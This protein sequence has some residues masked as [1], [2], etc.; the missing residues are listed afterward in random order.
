MTNNTG[1]LDNQ[2]PFLPS[3]DWEL[4]TAILEPENETYPW[5]LASD[6]VDAYFQKLAAPLY[7]D[8]L[9]MESLEQQ[10]ENFYNSLDQIWSQ[11]YNSKADR[12]ERPRTT[13]SDIFG[14]FVPSHYLDQIM[15]A[16]KK[17]F[18]NM[19]HSTIEK[20]VDCV[21]SLL[22]NWDMEDLL[23]LARP[24]AYSMRSGQS[25]YN[26]PNRNW[27][28]LSEVERAKICLVVADYALKAVST[29]AAENGVTR[30]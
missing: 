24:I 3:V 6:Q 13:L 18:H 14:T 23:V 30:K 12:D 27:T 9:F 10:G 19:E 5:N 28:E 1:D 17:T 2:K 22:P 21:R 7:S 11:V 8:P 16:A 15:E 29:Q 26:L 25:D 20:I 4:L